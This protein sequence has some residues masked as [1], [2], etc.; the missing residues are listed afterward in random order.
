MPLQFTL[1]MKDR[2][3]DI[4]DVTGDRAWVP[5]MGPLLAEPTFKPGARI[6]YGLDMAYR[7]RAV[8][9]WL[10]A[11]GELKPSKGGSVGVRLDANDPAFNLSRLQ[12]RITAPEGLT[13]ANGEVVDWAAVY[14]DAPK[15]DQ[16]VYLSKE[17]PKP[18]QKF[19]RGRPGFGI[20]TNGLD[21]NAD[22]QLVIT[23][24][25][26]TVL[27]PVFTVPESQALSVSYA[28]TFGR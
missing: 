20:A 28:M 10:D 18:G 6:P 1:R 19:G 16:I 26:G 3:T 11:D 24:E 9:M 17:L 14:F 21:V 12:Y 4:T 5:V 15:D 27:P 23:R 7:P 2:T 25:D 13:D 8:L 22:G